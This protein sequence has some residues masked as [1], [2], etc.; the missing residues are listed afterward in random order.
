MSVG[1]GEAV[2]I[3]KP[4]NLSFPGAGLVSA[5]QLSIILNVLLCGLAGEI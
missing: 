5:P 1:N 4:N 3:Q 2:S